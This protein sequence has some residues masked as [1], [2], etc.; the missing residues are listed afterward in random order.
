MRAF[1][2]D[3]KTFATT[4]HNLVLDYELK[5][6][7]YDTVSGVT[8]ETPSVL[9]KEGDIIYLEN[10]FFGVVKTISP[11]HGKTVLSVNQIITL[12]GRNVFYTPA[13]F[14]YLEDYIAQ[15]IS[16]NYVNCPDAFYAVPYL[17]VTA[18]THT[19]SDMRPDLEENV[20]SVKSYAA[21]MRRLYNIFCEWGM[22]RETLKLNIV[23][24]VKAV[25]NI[26][27]SNSDYIL[28]TQDFSDKTVSKITSYCKE[29][30]QTQNWVL[31]EDGSIVNT[32]PASGRLDGDWITLIVEEAADVRDSVKD[33]FARNEYSHKIEFQAPASK[34]F[35]LY[36]RLKVK[37]DNKIFGS[38]VSG[39]TERKGSNRVD[40]QCGELQ[41]EY[42][43]LELL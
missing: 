26:D 36:D 32:S 33:E 38:Y 42:P 2:K 5:H 30:D 19:A 6:S 15:L 37:L 22:D 8:I 31:L 25:K 39:V 21:K 29:N 7:I 4:S 11:D 10:G 28:L 14:Q 17:D 24:R 35:R 13:S 20:Y 34:G 9:P 3:Y 1:V 40:I 23:Q 41:M 27:F 43:Y 16:S 18:L 12:L